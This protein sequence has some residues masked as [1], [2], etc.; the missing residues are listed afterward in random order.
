[1]DLDGFAPAA[2]RAETRARL[3][4]REDEFVVTYVGTMGMAHGLATVLDAA[5]LTRGEPIR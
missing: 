4:V 1:M 5:E 3:G 2:G